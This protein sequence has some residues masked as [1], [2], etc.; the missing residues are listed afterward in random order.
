MKPPSDGEVMGE[1]WKEMLDAA[2]RARWIIGVLCAGW[3][4]LILT[5]AVVYA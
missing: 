2:W 1:L 4:L 3:A 5:M